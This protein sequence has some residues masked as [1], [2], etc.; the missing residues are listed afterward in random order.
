MPLAANEEEQTYREGH[1]SDTYEFLAGEKKQ[2]SAAFACG[3]S[4]LVMPTVDS[5]KSDDNNIPPVQI[6]FGNKTEGFTVTLP[7][8]PTTAEDATDSLRALIEFS[9]PSRSTD[10]TGVGDERTKSGVHTL[11]T[12]QFLTDFCPYGA[13]IV[14]VVG[15]MLLPGVK[16]NH[17]GVKAELHC[18]SIQSAP[19]GKV[20]IASNTPRSEKHFGTL[21]VCLPVD[22]EGGELIVRH[23]K[24]EVCF[25]WS[26]ESLDL[27]TSESAAIQWAAFY[28][29]TEQE[30]LEVKG[31]HRI[32]LTY[33]LFATPSGGMMP[34]GLLDPVQL[35]LHALLEG[36]LQCPSF[37]SKGR[38]LAF[39]TTHN[40]AHTSPSPDISPA[41]LK[42]ADKALY[43]IVRNLGLVCHIKIMYDVEHDVRWEHEGR[44]YGVISFMH[45]KPQRFWPAE[46]PEVYTDRGTVEWA[47]EEFGRETKVP[48]DMVTWVGTRRE[49]ELAVL[50]SFN[51]ECEYAH[52][53][54]KRESIPAFSYI[55]LMVRIPPSS[56]RFGPTGPD[57]DEGEH[58]GQ[59]ES[60]AEPSE[61][62]SRHT[63][64]A[65]IKRSWS[66]TSSRWLPDKEYSHWDSDSDG[67]D[68]DAD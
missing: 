21:I 37:F 35:P 61:A 14:D 42:G 10:E 23:T 32:T 6:R 13:G 62:T 16:G 56:D 49:E 28:N 40:Y 11:S 7:S 5:D 54:E 17:C 19:S 34:I 38:V 30:V 31:G 48:A 25:D 64:F 3:G 39:P 60:K 51:R 33:D 47:L 20:K 4:I 12:K 57:Q 52:W 22:H 8:L 26:V 45:D 58:A 1:S 15:K 55:A 9:V 65:G 29:K 18:L 43:E 27:A 59:V 46:F 44:R 2:Q 50:I 36:A 67:D 63:L 68:C 24:K 53:H 41:S 66:T